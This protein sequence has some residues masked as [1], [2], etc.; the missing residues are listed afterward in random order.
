[1]WQKWEELLSV[2]LGEGDRLE[3]STEIS[4]GTEQ[5]I[6]RRHDMICTRP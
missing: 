2:R 1:M 4:V 6:R 3:T 5:K